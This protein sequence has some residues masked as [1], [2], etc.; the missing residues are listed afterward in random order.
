VSD[1]DGNSHRPD[2]IAFTQSGRVRKRPHYTNTIEGSDVTLP[3]SLDFIPSTSKYPPPSPPSSSPDGGR[4]IFSEEVTDVIY[5]MNESFI[6][7]RSI[8]FN[9]RTKIRIYLLHCQ[10]LII[11]LLNL[12]LQRF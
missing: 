7:S 6:P 11:A 4:T 10:H 12:S 1:Y 8:G 3:I 5:S 9:M 2:Q